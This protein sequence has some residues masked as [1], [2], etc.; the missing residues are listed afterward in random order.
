[1]R[2]TSARARS[3]ALPHDWF[4]MAYPIAIPKTYTPTAS[5]RKL[6]T[7][8]KSIAIETSYRFVLSDIPIETIPP[9]S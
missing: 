3:N 7:A 5:K 1:M 2:V 9:Q 8:K 6:R 4:F